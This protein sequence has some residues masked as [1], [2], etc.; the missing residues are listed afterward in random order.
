ME[1]IRYLVDE[2]LPAL[3]RGLLVSVSLIVPSLVLGL[4]GGILLGTARVY[5][6]GWLRRLCDGIVLVFRGFPLVIQL[7]IWYFGLPR[8][9]VYLSPYTASVCG[10]VCCSAA[11]HSEYIRGALLSI[12]P[13]QMLAGHAIG[14]TAFQT[15]RHVILPQAVRRALP[16]CGNEIIYL[17]KYSSLAYMITCIELTGEGKILASAS[18]KYFEVFLT[19]GIVYLLLVTLVSRALEALE[20]HLVIPGFER[21]RT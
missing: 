14:L 9:G 17:V 11:Y 19:V 3:W 8:I 13:G 18:F 1:E 2:V 10:F 21:Y 12:R 15:I 16:G 20:T 6:T 4:A 7:Y 5:G